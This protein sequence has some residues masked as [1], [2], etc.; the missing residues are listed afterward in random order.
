[1]IFRRVI[2]HFRKR[3]W[4]ANALDFLIVVLAFQITEWNKAWR[5]HWQQ[6]SAEVGAW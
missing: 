3:E 5:E 1:M 6:A 4:T 2:A